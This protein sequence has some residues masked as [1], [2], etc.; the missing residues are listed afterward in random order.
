M[1]KPRL[2]PE[3]YHVGPKAAIRFEQLAK[4]VLTTPPPPKPQRGGRKKKR[5][6]A[7]RH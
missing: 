3:D 1:N 7:E 6:S 5:P 2:G 4:K